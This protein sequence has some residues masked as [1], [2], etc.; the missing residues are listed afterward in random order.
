[1]AD[2]RISLGVDVN[3]EG[4]QGKINAAAS[5]L[6]PI[7]LDVELGDI[8]GELKSLSKEISNIGKSIGTL[9]SGGGMKSLLASINQIGNA[10]EGVTAQFNGLTSKNGVRGMA[11]A[12]QQ[13]ARQT[14][15]IISD[16]AAKSIKKISS[17]EIGEVFKVNKIDSEAFENEMNNLVKKWT[18]GKGN[19]VDIQIE[20][21]THFDKDAQKNIEKLSKAHVTYKN[22]ANESIKKTLEWRQIG[23]EEGQIGKDGKK[24]ADIPI[25]GWVESHAKYQKSMEKTS[26]QT[27][28]FVKRQKQAMANLT[29]QINELDRDARDQAANRPIKEQG[30]LDALSKQYNDITAAIQRMGNASS[31]TFDDEQIRVKQLISEYKSMKK[32][33]KNAENVAGKLSGDDFESGKKIAANRLGKLKINSANYAEMTDTINGLYDAMKNVTDA[34][35]LKDFNSQLKVAEARLS[36]I[37]TKATVNSK[38]EILGINKSG[39]KSEIES[40]QKANPSLAKFEAEID[41]AKVS[42]HSLLSELGKV[43]T[44]GDFNV[45]NKKFAEFAK[46]AKNAGAIVKETTTQAEQVSKIQE[47]LKDTGFDGYAEEIKRAKTEMGRFEDSSGKIQSALQRL[48]SAMEAINTADEEKDMRKLVEAN[49]EYEA[50]LKRV[51]SLKKQYEREERQG[52]DETSLELD[53]AKALLRL[54]N[55]FESGSQAAKVYGNQMRELREE[56]AATA[57]SADIRQVNKKIGILDEMVERD[58]LQRQTLGSRLKSQLQKYSQYF[59]VAQLMMYAEQGIRDMF[60]QVKLIDSAMTELKK[61]TNETD[62]SYDQFLSKAANRAKELGTTIDGLVGS[63]ADFARLGYSFEESQGLAEV[64]NVYAVVGDEIDGVDGATQSLVSTLAAFKHEMGDMSDSEFAMS[65]VDK[66][67]E[68]SNNFAISSGGIGEALQRSASSLAAANNTLDESIAMITA[69]NEV[70]QNP[71]KVGNAMKTKFLYNCLNVQKCA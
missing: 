38:N 26:S 23:A 11:Q 59:S 43:K 69:A 70:A 8:K 36:K 3:T 41:G 40:L 60:E 27:D 32:E 19:I 57:D 21:R 61:V 15:R 1:M 37:K 45:V 54:E 14:E 35:S 50:A 6:D 28:A 65:I 71:E 55:L 67:N 44:Q 18:S 53:R 48:D 64:A 56:I 25:M 62:A 47:K 16:S 9:D 24:G 31:S 17:K 66:F 33:F 34:S 13:A 42:V 58:G 20:T 68:V 49:K 2:F 63:T 12:A 7:K 22:A 30:H 10:L 52:Y 51:N 39:L 4:L 46:S 29:N 5:Q